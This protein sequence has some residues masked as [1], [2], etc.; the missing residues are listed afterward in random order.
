MFG[1]RLREEIASLNES[2]DLAFKTM[3][4]D[5]EIAEQNKQSTDAALS[6][7][8][9][10]LTNLRER[11]DILDEENRSLRAVIFEMK[12]AQDLLLEYLNREVKF[13]PESVRPPKY[14]LVERK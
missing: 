5:R 6:A 1:T 8:S 13:T 4:S 11:L 9:M 14:E 3:G 2:V 12:H 10:F 7:Q